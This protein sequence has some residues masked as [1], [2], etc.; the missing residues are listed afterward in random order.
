[1]EDTNYRTEPLE[2]AFGQEVALA[3]PIFLKSAHRSNNNLVVA[4]DIVQEALGEAWKY[5]LNNGMPKTRN[6]FVKWGVHIIGWKLLDAYKQTKKL[7]MEIPNSEDFNSLDYMATLPRRQHDLVVNEAI[8][9][10]LHKSFSDRVAT[11]YYSTNP[12]GAVIPHI[13]DGISM[14]DLTSKF[15]YSPGLIAK[16]KKTLDRIVSEVTNP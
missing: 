16:T 5:A 1:M 6:E 4:E 3:Y 12:V 15:G 9:N 14:T 11:L 2:E 13:L 10:E 7:E 8:Y